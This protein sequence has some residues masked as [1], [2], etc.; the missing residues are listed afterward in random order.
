[1]VVSEVEVLYYLV[2]SAQVFPQRLVIGYTC[3]QDS[4]LCIDVSRVAFREYSLGCIISYGREEYVLFLPFLA[5]AAAS[6]MVLRVESQSLCPL[7]LL[8][9]INVCRTFGHDDDVRRC[10]SFREVAQ[11][12]KRQKMIL[13]SR[14][15]IVN[16]NDG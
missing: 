15:G 16:K 5:L 2:A 14:T 13:E 11:S 7:F 10:N 1:M 9:C 8:P 4:S 6:G 3:E 12:A